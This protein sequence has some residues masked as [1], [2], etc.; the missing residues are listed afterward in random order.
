MDLPD[1]NFAHLLLMTDST[2]ILQHGRYTVPRYEEGYCR[3]RPGA[4]LPT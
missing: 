3:R 1:R 2:G 4:E